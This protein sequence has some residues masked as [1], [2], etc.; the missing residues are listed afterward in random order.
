VEK[1]RDELKALHEP[2]PLAIRNGVADLMVDELA[3]QYQK[4]RCYGSL[5]AQWRKLAMEL[6][7]ETDPDPGVGAVSNEA[8]LEYARGVLSSAWRQSGE[9]ETVEDN[10]RLAAVVR[11]HGRVILEAIEVA[12]DDDEIDEVEENASAMMVAAAKALAEALK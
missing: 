12:L 4:A 11:E 2:R 6:G 7:A 5:A 10:A 3:K 8:A 1:E 9:T